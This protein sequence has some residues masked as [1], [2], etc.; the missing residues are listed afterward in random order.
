[1]Q[2][3]I[4]TEACRQLDA[5]LICS[6][7]SGAFKQAY[8]IEQGSNKFALKIALVSGELKARF[9]REISALKECAHPS[10]AKIF[11]SYL[12]AYQ[13]NEYWVIVEEYLPHGTLADVMAKHP[14]DVGAIRHLGN[15]L[16]EALGHL[17]ERSFVH[18]DI[19]PANI[20][21]RTPSEPV[22]TDFGIVRMLGEVS[23]TQDFMAQGPGTPM[24][25]SPE[26]LLNE[27]SA[28]DWRTDQFGLALVLAE[29]LLGH[30]AFLENP[31]GNPRDAISLVANRKPVP[32]RT[33][34]LLTDE[35]FDCLL[36]ALS[37]W[38]VQRY[39]KPDEFIRALSGEA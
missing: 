21:F 34:R 39:R 12:I 30:H 2:K 24:Y 26:Q 20:L 6:L 33:R 5:K 25:A 13:G 17:F 36:K 37:P 38:S 3:D 29:L 32:L 27:K 35:G 28:I 9:E 18:R 4:T 11:A 7:G 22:L 8:L 10:I 1:M 19:K 23:L 16:A 31:Q 14:L 15:T